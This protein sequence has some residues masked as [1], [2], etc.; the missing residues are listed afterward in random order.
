MFTQVFA[1]GYSNDFPQSH[2]NCVA[3]H[4]TDG[5][6]AV[7]VVRFHELVRGGEG[8]ENRALA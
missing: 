8:L 6:E 4:P 3:N 1:N 7:F 5:L 2:R